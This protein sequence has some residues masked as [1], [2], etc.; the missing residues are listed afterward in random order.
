MTRTMIRTTV[1]T[2]VLCLG[3]G[4]VSD[5]AAAWGPQAERSIAHMAMQVIQ[6]EHPNVFTP[7]GSGNFASDVF[8][9]ANDGITALGT[10]PMLSDAE[11]LKAVEEEIQLLRDV[12]DYGPS[13]YFAYRMGVLSTMTANVMLPYGY[14]RTAQERM[15]QQQIRGDIEKQLETFTISPAQRGMRQIRDA[16]LHFKNLRPFHTENMVI[17]AEEYKRGVGYNGFLKLAASAYFEEAVLAVA[18]AWHTVL[19]ARPEVAQH[20]TTRPRLTDYFVEEVSYLLNVRDNYFQANRIYP[21]F[22]QVN[23]REARAY[24]RLGDLYYDYGLAKRL[25]ESVDR[26]VREWQVAHGLR[27]KTHLQISRK[28]SNHYIRAGRDELEAGQVKGAGNEELPSAMVS[29][30]TAIKYDPANREA[31]GMI[32]AAQKAMKERRELLDTRLGIIASGDL[33]RARAEQSINV[34]DFGNAITDYGMA[35]SLYDSVDDFFTD[36]YETAIDNMDEI[37][38]KIN[39]AVQKIEDQAN[40]ALGEGDVAGEERQYEVAINHYKR[41]INILEQIPEDGVSASAM[42]MK[43]KTLKA[44]NDSIDRAKTEKLAWDRQQQ[45]LANQGVQP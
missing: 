44:A 13:S 17:I 4:L 16:H 23:P 39:S 38:K 20:P 25:A 33:V 11:T 24:E 12:R 26:G 22:R 34:Q 8:R 19:V 1:L 27:G 29:F 31:P 5:D 32:E 35:L 6:R 10:V 9:G 45:Q 21:N 15:L 30:E 42:S 37:D 40:D 14:A 28:L 36:L 43:E 18:D 2:L 3:A 7:E 41:A